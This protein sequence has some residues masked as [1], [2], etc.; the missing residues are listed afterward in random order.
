MRLIF[1]FLFLPLTIFPQ[2]THD[3][4]TNKI[5]NTRLAYSLDT[6]NIQDKGLWKYITHK[7]VLHIRDSFVNIQVNPILNG[8]IFFSNNDTSNLYRNTRGFYVTG[9]ILDKIHFETFFTENQ[10]FAPEYQSQYISTYGIYPGQG[11]V[12][13]FKTYGFDF[14]QSQANIFIKITKRWLFGLGNGKHF[15]GSGYRSMLLSDVSF[16][17]PYLYNKVNFTNKI[18]YSVQ[19]YWLQNLVRLSAYNTSEPSFQ[20]K[21]MSNYLFNVEISKFFNT[22]IYN[23]HISGNLDS[24]YRNTQPNLLFY[25]PLPFIN[26]MIDRSSYSYS[27]LGLSFSIKKFKLYSQLASDKNKNYATQWGVKHVL[28]S[29]KNFQSEILLEHN[30]A[31]PNMYHDVYGTRTNMVH[32]NQSIIHPLNNGFKEYIAKGSFLMLKRIGLNIQYMYAGFY[33]DSLGVSS[34]EKIFNVNHQ[35]LNTSYIYSNEHNHVQFLNVNI[36]YLLNNIYNLAFFTEFTQ[37]MEQN[38]YNNRK[39]NVFYTI[40]IKTYLHKEYFDF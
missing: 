18:S 32:Y 31:M 22:Y 40:G 34:K 12:K 15:I 17:F 5:L 29:I 10:I 2:F 11:R 27:G 16:N 19:Q 7:N 6:I 9:N 21:Y 25:Q 8:S 13:N 4:F 26:Q 33:I 24:V 20:R 3:F 35:N 30:T 38:I 36:Y 37:R 39:T 1:I 28:K 23:A 14:A